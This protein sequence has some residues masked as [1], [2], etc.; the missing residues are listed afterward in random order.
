M[1]DKTEQ[2]I[3]SALQVFIRKGFQATTQE[4]ANEAKVAEV[5]LFRKFGNKQQLFITVVKSVLEKKFYAHLMEQA[6]TNDTEEFLRSII[7]NRLNVLSR[8][9]NLVRM[10]IA[11]SLMEN[12]PPEIN[13]PDMI[14]TSLTHGIEQHAQQN[15]LVIDSNY[16]ARQLSGIFLSHLILPTDKPY[17]ELS[18]DEKGSLLNKYVAPFLTLNN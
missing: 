11:E 16:W 1:K 5:T 9:R 10:L 3:Q 6:K 7:D 18:E 12:L 4:V 2:I 15:N 14:F 8:N 17:N 13:L